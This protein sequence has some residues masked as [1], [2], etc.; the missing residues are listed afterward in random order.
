MMVP[1]PPKFT[2]SFGFP[3]KEQILANE[4]KTFYVYSYVHEVK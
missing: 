3:K 1:I 2:D 4:E